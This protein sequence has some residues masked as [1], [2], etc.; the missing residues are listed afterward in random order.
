MNKVKLAIQNNSNKFATE[1]FEETRKIKGKLETRES[2]ANS[3]DRARMQKVLMEKMKN[4]NNPKL[5]DVQYKR[6]S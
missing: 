2:K 5:R 3:L 4:P 1:D 6:K